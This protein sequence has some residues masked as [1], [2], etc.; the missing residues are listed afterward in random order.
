MTTL[1]TFKFI[2]DSA[3]AKAET[4]EDIKEIYDLWDNVWGILSSFVFHEGEYHKF[5]REGMAKIVEIARL[6]AQVHNC[7]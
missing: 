5:E 4:L 1:E 3:A 2:H 7:E 6:K